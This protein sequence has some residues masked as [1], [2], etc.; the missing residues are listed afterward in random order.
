MECHD[1]RTAWFKSPTFHPCLTL[2]PF[3]I[4]E[5]LP[6]LYVKHFPSKL[7]GSEEGRGASCLFRIESER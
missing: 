1:E 4:L 2:H 7:L 5:S 6:F 3:K